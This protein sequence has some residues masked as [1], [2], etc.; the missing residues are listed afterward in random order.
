MSPASHVRLAVEL[1]DSEAYELAQF[2]RRVRFE[3][4]A[5]LTECGQSRERREE[6]AY[7]MLYALNQVGG[8]L[9]Q[10]GYAPR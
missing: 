5:E 1:T 3:Q 10:V 8:A 6:Q 9:R 4:V 7:R 2:I